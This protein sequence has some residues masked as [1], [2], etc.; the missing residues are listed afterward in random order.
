MTL[1]VTRNT[2][3][4]NEDIV[5]CCFVD[6]YDNIL[7]FFYNDEE[8][9]EI[10]ILA[11]YKK[12]TGRSK[13]CFMSTMK[14]QNPCKNGTTAYLYD[15]KHDDEQRCSSSL[16]SSADDACRDAIL[17]RFSRFG[18]RILCHVIQSN[19]NYLPLRGTQI[20]S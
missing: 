8:K 14:P 9:N 19:A 18:K 15:S 12:E 5:L 7:V 6:L 13:S 11:A 1:I 3:A 10:D 16:R 4:R 17:A 20:I 2:N